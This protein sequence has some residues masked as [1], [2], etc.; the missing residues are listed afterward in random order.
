[1]TKP[2]G[3]HSGGGH[4]AGKSDGHAAK[5]DAAKSGGDLNRRKFERL[6]LTEAAYA[7]DA[8]GR[9]LGKVTQASG[10]GMMIKPKSAEIAKSLPQGERVTITVMEPS[11]QTQHTLDMVVRYSSPDQI[12][13][14]FVGGR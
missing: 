9:E 5:P 10:G 3:H 12:G 7:V 13:L 8:T 14:E 1:V 4:S 6:E 11:S 2:V